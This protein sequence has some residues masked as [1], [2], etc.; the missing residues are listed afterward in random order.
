[1]GKSPHLSRRHTVG[2]G[3]VA[4]GVLATLVSAPKLAHAAATSA[5]A[6]TTPKAIPKAE[7]AGGPAVALFD[8][9]LYAAWVG[10]TGNTIWYSDFNG[11]SWSAQKKVPSALTSAGPALSVY[12]G[13]LYLAWIGQGPAPYHVWYSAFNG[14]SW[15][16]Q[17]TVPSALADGEYQTSPA[18]AGYH[19][20]LYV[21]WIGQPPAPY[22]V[23][24]STFN[25]T[26]WSAQTTIPGAVVSPAL[27]SQGD[28][29]L[30]VY[31]GDLYAS[32][33]T[34]SCATY[35]ITYADFNGTAW[36][37]PSN[38]SGPSVDDY[39]PTGTALGVSNGSLYDAWY[40]PGAVR[41]SYISFNGKT[42]S[43]IQHVP[44]SSSLTCNTPSVVGYDGALFVAWMGSGTTPLCENSGSVAYSSGP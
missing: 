5:S 36:S 33:M 27:I 18:L 22:H 23:W 1:M 26:T 20:N 16:A 7:T 31:S 25:G 12:G 41:V 19:G 30:T 24:Y 3:L 42:W 28:A 15:S 11:T 43:S 8:G 38:R 9:L 17:A 37:S 14:T 39:P 21:S 10:K 35:C 13:E 4:V 44:S 34:G 2:V 29:A 6:W 40:D 32:W